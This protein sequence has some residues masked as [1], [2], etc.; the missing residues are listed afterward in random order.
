ETTTEVLKDSPQSQNGIFLHFYLLNFAFL[1]TFSSV[2]S[3]HGVCFLY[4]SVIVIYYAEIMSL[5]LLTVGGSQSQ[6]F[7]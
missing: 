4:E 7:I 3:D 2:Y 6:L 5:I 1:P